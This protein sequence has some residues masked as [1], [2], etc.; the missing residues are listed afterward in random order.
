MAVNPLAPDIA[1][2]APGLFD[3]QLGGAPDPLA[4]TPTA[5]VSLPGEAAPVTPDLNV[6]EADPVDAAGE[7]EQVAGV[8]GSAIRAA[9]K[10]IKDR[11]EPSMPKGATIDEAIEATD[12]GTA[13]KFGEGT[14]EGG[15]AFTV[16]REVTDAE[17]AAY[18][19]TIGNT[20]GKPS[21]GMADR[22]NDMPVT[23][24]NLETIKSTD[25]LKAAIDTVAQ[26]WET[27]GKKAGRG[28]MT[29][30]EIQELGDKM[31]F[32]NTVK[33]ILGR[34]ES[35]VFNAETTSSA[36]RAMA[37]SAFELDRL[38]KVVLT[39]TDEKVLIQ[40]RQHMGLHA[41]ITIQMKGAS[42][43]AGRALGAWRTTRTPGTDAY[44]QEVKSMI[45]DMG[46]DKG[47]REM[48]KNYLSI[49]DVGG[50]NRFA[51]SGYQKVKGAYFEHVINGMLSS[52]ATLLA[53]GMG[54][55]AF[56]LMT[57]VE[58]PIEAAISQSF[59]AIGLNRKESV[60]FGEVYAD[61]HGFFQG[62]GDGVQLGYTAFKTNA[63]VR[64]V[65]SK[66]ETAHRSVITGQNLAP[67]GPEW[68]QRALD[69]YGVMITS[70]G[71]TLLATDE[72]YKGV[73]HRRYINRMAVRRGLEM[74]RAGASGNEIQQGVENV[75]LGI[76]DAANDAAIKFS[77]YSTFTDPVQGLLGK[78]GSA[79]QST[80]LGRLMM[81]FFRTPVKITSAQLQRTPLLGLLPA[82]KN[83]KDPIK[84]D[85]A[86]ARHAFGTAAAG[87]ITYE[88]GSSGK[89]TGSG[90]LDIDLHNQLLALKWEPYSFA[91]A[92]EG[93]DNPRWLKIGHIQIRHP[94]DVDYYSYE[95][96]EPIGAM[97]AMAANYSQRAYWPARDEEKIGDLAIATG[98]AM[99]HYLKRMSFLSSFTTLA[100]L[101]SARTPEA[102]QNALVKFGGRVAA[103]QKPFSALLSSAER[104]VD[105]TIPDT[106]E[107]RTTAMLLREFKFLYGRFDSGNPWREQDGPV[108]R[109]RFAEPRHQKNARVLQVFLPPFI[110]DFLGDDYDAIMEDPVLSRVMDAG[111]PLR[112]VPK[113][114][115]GVLLTSE[116]RETLVI[117][118]ATPPKV[119]DID[120]EG[121]IIP[122]SDMGFPSLRERLQTVFNVADFDKLPL[123]NRQ[124]LIK[125]ADEGTRELAIHLILNHP[126]Y[127]E[128][129]RDLR[130]KVAQAKAEA[131]LP[132]QVK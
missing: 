8:V 89:I 24:F 117:L 127:E 114:I 105:D 16:V 3:G 6:I 62:I 79:I 41:A 78:T 14:R 10:A 55:T 11:G 85:A 98:D 35:E 73:A 130:E 77:Q 124:T 71:R 128:E 58:T 39:T 96:M 38:A 36:L 121:N 80:M 68:A 118:A 18:R 66:L 132:E 53:N 49:S 37:V 125:S 63:P 110:A 56:S 123:E 112:H 122:G 83:I 32:H 94:E 22:L 92:K 64:D 40:F 116:E 15:S 106:G 26:M 69:W 108:L 76:D 109:D 34:E 129:F 75:L 1:A 43:E 50:R 100:S 33:R 131:K 5:P 60:S 113:K 90:P 52:P 51:M 99:F 45:N 120:R 119:P 82:L 31:G 107:D 97:L 103:S 86:L 84:R 93:V 28:K 9:R 72:F 30:A 4:V 21:P 2:P 17:V 7:G 44:L 47:I 12:G 101:L 81:P 13:A 57:L 88:F 48:A 65:A 104:L 59:R 19:S 46:G 70:P 23:E 25:D 74:K 61:I 95:R 126:F 111:V 29:L 67:D 20:T 102:I 87:W 42:I 54:N 27:N 91:F 115:E